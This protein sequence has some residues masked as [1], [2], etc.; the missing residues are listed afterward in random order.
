L[1]EVGGCFSSC[2]WFFVSLLSSLLWSFGIAMGFFV[3]RRGDC[4]LNDVNW[5]LKKLDQLDAWLGEEKKKKFR[6]L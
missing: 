4:A 1:V 6:S 3:S 5:I 2:C